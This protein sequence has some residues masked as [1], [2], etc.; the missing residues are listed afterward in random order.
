MLTANLRVV[1]DYDG[2]PEVIADGVPFVPVSLWHWGV[3]NLR[4][5]V[6]KYPDLHL[7]KYLWPQAQ[8][9]VTRRGLQLYRGLY[10]MGD[11]MR[12]QSWFAQAL[13]RKDVVN[14]LYHPL[15]SGS[16]VA[17][18]SSQHGAACD[19][20]LTR[21]SQRWGNASFSEIAALELQRKRQNAAAA[22]ANLPDQLAASHRT[23]EDSAHGRR[24]AEQAKP[25]G[26]TRAERTR[27]ISGNRE[28]EL[29]ALTSAAFLNTTGTDPTGAVVAEAPSPATPKV[30]DATSRTADSVRRIFGARRP[31]QP[32]SSD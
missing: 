13:H 17:L 19:V 6:R 14:V 18:P 20:V 2:W 28:A 31:A 32:S 23:I 4:A 30:E 24:L 7:K 3:E 21:R 9:T 27:G 25:P 26:E 11:A 8:M 1:R 15:M 10:Y 16:A 22:W 12:H 5:D 29:G